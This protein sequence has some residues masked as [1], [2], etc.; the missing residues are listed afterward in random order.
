MLQKEYHPQ[1]IPFYLGQSH[2]EAPLAV[3]INLDHPPH[4]FI[5]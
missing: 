4:I 5:R 3:I 2:E 1:K